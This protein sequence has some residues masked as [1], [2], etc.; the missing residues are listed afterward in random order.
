MKV[1]TSQIHLKAQFTLREAF[2][3]ST[4]QSFLLPLT[5]HDIHYRPHTCSDHRRTLTNIRFESFLSNPRDPTSSK[6][7]H[8]L[9]LWT[10]NLY[11][12]QDSRDHICILYTYKVIC[13]VS[14]FIHSQ[15]LPS[16]LFTWSS[17]FRFFKT[18]LSVLCA[19]LF[20][21]YQ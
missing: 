7:H 12:A 5:L 3:M 10:H 16:A 4:L 20:K 14:S 21:F 9:F 17:M 13:K 18:V 6:K 2:L 19:L 11:L 15:I 8:T 1:T